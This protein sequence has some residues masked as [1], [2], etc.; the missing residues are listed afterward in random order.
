[1]RVAIGWCLVFAGLIG[2]E[3][4]ELDL[5]NILS[6]FDLDAEL[7]AFSNECLT[8][9]DLVGLWDH[10]LKAFAARALGSYLPLAAAETIGLQELRSALNMSSIPPWTYYRDYYNYQGQELVER[11]TQRERE[12]AAAKTLEEYFELRDPSSHRV[13]LD[14]T[15]L[16]ETNMPPAVAYMDR[17]FPVIRR[18]FRHKMEEVVP[19]AGTPLDRP[20]IDRAI[21]EFEAISRRVDQAIEKLVFFPTQKCYN[22]I[23][24][25]AAAAARKRKMVE[26]SNTDK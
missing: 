3:N 4:L 12:L 26:N 17:R 1:M 9:D 7:A 24:A 6:P 15:F 13:S 11:N 18:I 2:A 20:T 25:E 19:P 21:A 8:D 23:H 10:K 14:S 5:A 22:Q 16:V